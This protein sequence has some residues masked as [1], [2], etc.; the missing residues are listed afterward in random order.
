MCAMRRPRPLS[1]VLAAALLCAAAVAQE[2]PRIG[3]VLSGGGARGIAHV[4]V[5]QV[6]EELRIPVDVVVGTSMGAIV[7][8]SYAYGYTADELEVAVVRSGD[9][10]SWDELLT[11]APPRREQAFRRKQEQLGFLIDFGLGYGDGEFR[12]PKGILQGQNLELELL[13]MLPMAH[14]LESFDELPL[15]FR[16]VGVDLVGREVVLERGNL[17]TAM[18]ASMSLPALFA[19]VEV[20]GRL[21]LDGGLVR[22]V[23]IEVA[24]ELGID[25]AIVVHIGTPLEDVEVE[26][27]LDVSAQMLAILTQQNVDRSLKALGP[28]DLLLQ[29]DLGDITSADFNRATE[30]VALGQ[31]AA[32]AA[33]EQLARFSV[34][35]QEY[36]AW[37]AAHKTA[38]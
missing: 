9:L 26:S 21:V 22:N 35:E 8:G 38:A 10:R 7:G 36:A 23:P 20:D 2:R 37:R 27:A 5:L 16:A 1:A 13:E 17:A 15:P 11:D 32:Q 34:S 14:A 6:M 19:P 30:L 3:L 25:A 29:P 33:T 31:A 12:L 4:G 28:E 18:R 24:R